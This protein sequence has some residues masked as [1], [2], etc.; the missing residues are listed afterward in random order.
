MPSSA[1]SWA[2]AARPGL[3]LSAAQE[4]V[5]SA[6]LCPHPSPNLSHEAATPPF[7]FLCIR[8]FWA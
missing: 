1:V 5:G 2:K 8:L 6:S 7:L 4:A 3:Q